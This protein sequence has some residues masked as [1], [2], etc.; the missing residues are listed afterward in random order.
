M[1]TIGETMRVI[2]LTFSPGV[3]LAGILAAASPAGAES[4]GGN[5]APADMGGAP[6]AMG[7]APREIVIGGGSVAGAYFPV[8]GAICRVVVARLPGA[9]C[10]VESNANSSANI[11]RLRSGLLDFAVVQSDWLMHAYRGTN[12]FRSQGPDES[13]RAVM[14]LHAEPL[15]MIAAA[16][17]GIETAAD[18]K[19]KRLN[20]GSAFTYQRVLTEATLWAFGIDEDD[21]ALAM[22]IPAVEQFPALCAGEIDAAG[23]VVAHAS[24]VLAEAMRQCDLKLVRIDGGKLAELLEDRPDLARAEIPGGLYAGVPD[25]VPSFGLRAVLATSS[26][27]DDEIVRA[28]LGAILESLPE[29]T[30][31]HPVLA[32][33]R[34]ES[35]VSA[36]IAIPLHEAASRYFKERGLLP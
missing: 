8:A 2:G 19:G 18:L 17:A 15:A 35:M 3:L 30:G 23:I 5:G 21:L 12:L 33:L 10:L 26:Q 20:L 29:F 36:G 7:G 28:I 11:E 22:E 1:N 13:L 32:R 24:P 9:R 25:A 14:S 27:T 6:A 34:P 4:H 31:Q 16:G